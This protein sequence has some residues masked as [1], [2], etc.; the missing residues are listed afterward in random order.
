MGQVQPD[1]CVFTNESVHIH[2]ASEPTEVVP[3]HVWVA[4][5]DKFQRFRQV[6]FFKNFMLRRVR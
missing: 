3:L 4:E 1:H 2:R 5:R 6:P